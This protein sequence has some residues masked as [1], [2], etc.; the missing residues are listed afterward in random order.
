MVGILW[1]FGK[2]EKG[3]PLGL[4]E[5][6]FIIFLLF[7]HLYLYGSDKMYQEY[8][9]FLVFALMLTLQKERK[10]YVSVENR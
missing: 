4:S 10:V 6:L 9:L 5:E 8:N 2:R 7:V 1:F 3:R